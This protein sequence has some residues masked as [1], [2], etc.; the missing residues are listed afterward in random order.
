MDFFIS[1]PRSVPNL[2]SQSPSVLLTLH[3]VN[4]P[5]APKRR[6]VDSLE[7]RIGG[8]F[9]E[10]RVGLL[11]AVLQIS[12]PR[13]IRKLA[14]R[15]I[16]FTRVKNHSTPVANHRQQSSAS[17]RIVTSS[18]RNRM[19]TMGSASW[20]VKGTKWRRPDH[21]LGEIRGAAFLQVN[22]AVGT[23][24][25]FPKEFC[26][27]SSRS[28]D[29]P[30]G[31]GRW[32]GRHRVRAL[33]RSPFRPANFRKPLLRSEQASTS[34]NFAYPPGC[35]DRYGSNTAPGSDKSWCLPSMTP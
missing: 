24:R 34:P 30:L 8:M 26:H 23:V 16:R 31:V 2:S 5:N 4:A 17:S 13:D 15:S 32:V 33:K 18:P 22:V 12:L 29:R 35:V 20:R 25:S 14:R 21:R 27:A 1:L 10:P 9:L 11:D 28:F 19:L 3:R 7:S 6:R